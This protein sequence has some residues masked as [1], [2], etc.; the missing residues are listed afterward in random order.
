MN[1]TYDKEWLTIAN[2]ALNLIGEPAIQDFTGS[3]EP[4]QNVVIQLPSAVEQVLSYHPFRCARKRTS[5]APVLDSPVYEYIYAYQ[6]PVD[7]VR[8]VS[9]YECEDYSLE[10]DKILANKDE[11]YICY[12][13]EPATP[14]SLTP[15]LREAVTVL[16]AYKI[17]KIATMNEAL[18]QRLYQEYQILITSA[19][20]DDQ[21]GVFQ[22]YDGDEWWTDE[23]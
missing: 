22:N 18:I 7:F 16:L 2:R 6:L 13:A 12:I 11:M 9:V 3:G 5:L 20:K 21:A 19:K 10:G 4:T 23:R 14:D 17:A 15:V 1:L 8:L